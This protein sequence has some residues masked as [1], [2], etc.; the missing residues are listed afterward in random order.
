[1]M[2][3]AEMTIERGE[4]IK[5][6]IVDYLMVNKIK[7]AL[8]LNAIGS[9]KDLVIAN[10]EE[11]EL[12]LKPVPTIFH[13]ACEVVSLSGEAMDWKECDP[14]LLKV[15]PDRDLP[16]FLHLHVSAAI[17][18]GHTFSGGLWGGTAFRSLRVFMMV[19]K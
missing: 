13:E 7:T 12:P 16:I 10:P 4:D 17:I 3:F 9:A 5:K 14:M 2:E 15:Y 11:H 18:G 6:T 8:F 1:M 19:E